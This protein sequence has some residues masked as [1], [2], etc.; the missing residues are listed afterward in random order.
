MNV[1]FTLHDSALDAAFLQASEAAG[2]L[3]LKGHKA[4]GGMRASLY[5]AVPLEAVQALVGFMA[6]FAQRHG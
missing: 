5:N 4:L 2:L 6:D 1:P 3:A